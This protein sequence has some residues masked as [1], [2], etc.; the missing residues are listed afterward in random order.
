M[1][2]MYLGNRK[3]SYVFQFQV[4]KI[5]TFL[6]INRSLINIINHYAKITPSI[7]RCIEYHCTRRTYAS[8]ILDKGVPINQI[9]L[10]LRHSSIQTTFH[11]LK[12][13]RKLDM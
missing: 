11:F 12:S 10:A 2:K 13:I 4:K 3:T 8:K 1:L 5:E 9:S 7:G 6:Y